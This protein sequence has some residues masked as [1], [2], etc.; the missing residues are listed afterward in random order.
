MANHLLKEKDRLLSGIMDVERWKSN[1]WRTYMSQ[2]RFG[3]VLNPGPIEGMPP[4]QFNK[5][6]QHQVKL[7][8]NSI[9]SLWFVDHLQFGDSPLLEGWTAL[10][11]LPAQYPQ[12]Q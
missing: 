12:F 6:V 5:A 1:R 7:V 4:Q 11:Y 2:V 10:S 9:D 8:E 3:W